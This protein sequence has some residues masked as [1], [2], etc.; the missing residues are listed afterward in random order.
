MSEAVTGLSPLLRRF[1][2]L[3]NR[4]PH[5][6]IGV[7]PTPLRELDSLRAALGESG[8]PSAIYLKDDGVSNPIYGGNKVRKLELVLAEA[9]RR[10][11]T[12][13]MTFGFAGSNHAT[14]TAVHAAT[15]GL[16]SISMLLPQANA[17]YV[18]KN[19]FIQRHLFIRKGVRF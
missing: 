10:G 13:V 15:L 6:P 19:L 7:F 2:A 3:A 4:L 17:P 11:A 16:R 12:E 9:V 8:G 1:P 18:A 14:A 5:T